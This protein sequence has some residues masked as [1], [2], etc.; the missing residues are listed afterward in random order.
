MSRCD[1]R[2]V[3]LAIYAVGLVSVLI[4]SGDGYV[5]LLMDGYLVLFIVVKSS[6]IISHF[7]GAL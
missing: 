7:N 5:L 2:Y 6:R 4:V 3:W 1:W